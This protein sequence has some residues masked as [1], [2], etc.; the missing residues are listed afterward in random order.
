MSV[1]VVKVN[2]WRNICYYFREERTGSLSGGG[3]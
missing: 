2:G 1:A 3:K